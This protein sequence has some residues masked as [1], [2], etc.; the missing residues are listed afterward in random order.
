MKQTVVALLTRLFASMKEGGTQYH[1]FV[2]PIIRETVVPGSPLHTSLLEEALD[3][4]CTVVQQ[5]PT[6]TPASTTNP[7]LLSLIELLIPLLDQDTEN[8]EK[9]IEIFEAYTLL[10]P[11][12]MLSRDVL[13]KVLLAFKGK[14][15]T[16]N[17]GHSGHVTK[18]V[19]LAWKAAFALQGVSGAQ[20]LTFQMLETGF[21]DGLING[22]KEAWEA[23]QTTGPKAIHTKIQG[24]IET[25]YLAIIS[26]I[27]CDSPEV[28][29]E[30]LKKS[31]AASTPPTASITS[32]NITPMDPPVQWLFDEWF[33]HIEDFGDPERHKLM[34][35]ALTKVLN[36]PQ[37]LLYSHMQSL[38]SLWTS[39]TIELTDETVDTKVDS[40]VWPPK[41]PEQEMELQSADE[42]RRSAIDRID[43]VHT[44]NLNE[45]IRNGLNEFIQRCGG[46]QKFREEILANVDQEVIKQFGALNIM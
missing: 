20:E 43:P 1:H 14:L 40:L 10:V 3:A 23:H 44:V 30:A 31:P 9:S 25:D 37:F 6:A 2:L 12:V 41:S 24:I 8:L 19:E 39:V 34:T 45:L 18:A 16:I 5:T 27:A 35:M 17:Y 29:L 26:R 38:L 11:D 22:L 13:P 21:F 42:R 15:G 33:S 36:L 7:E 46:E 4:W 32:K 28:F